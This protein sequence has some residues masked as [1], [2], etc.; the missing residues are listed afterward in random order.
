MGTHGLLGGNRGTEPG[1]KRVDRDGRA[2]RW[3]AWAGRDGRRWCVGR[4]RGPGYVRCEAGQGSALWVFV[5]V[6][7]RGA[8]VCCAGPAG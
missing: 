4:V 1:D 5:G 2:C 7:Q 3:V 8:G 6:A